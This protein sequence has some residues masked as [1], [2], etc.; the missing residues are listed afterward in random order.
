MGIQVEEDEKLK[1][2]NPPE[3]TLWQME[4]SKIALPYQWC[5]E[6]KLMYISSLV[7][8]KILETN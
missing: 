5:L 2:R 1:A 3:Q 4:M 7:V 6:T 8:K